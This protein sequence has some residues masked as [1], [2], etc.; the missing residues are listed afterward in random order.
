MFQHSCQSSRLSTVQCN[1][2]RLIL[3]G[4]KR[5]PNRFF[6]LIKCDGLVA[7][8]SDLLRESQYPEFYYNTFW[9]HQFALKSTNNLQYTFK[10][11][12]IFHLERQQR[13]LVSVAGST[14]NVLCRFFTCN[15]YDRI[16][17]DIGLSVETCTAII[18][19]LFVSLLPLAVKITK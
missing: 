15:C 4:H 17:I 16:F 13:Q 18:P 7:K 3:S 2:Y 9:R 14:I 11:K 19:I 8:M 10:S 5:K 6:C 1:T 12:F